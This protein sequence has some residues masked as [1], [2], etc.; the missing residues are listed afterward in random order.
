MFKKREIPEVHINWEEMNTFEEEKVEQALRDEKYKNIISFILNNSKL[1]YDK[2]RL[3]IDY[4]EVVLEYIK[5]IEPEAYRTQYNALKQK[6]ENNYGLLFCSPLLLHG[7]TQ[8]NKYHNRK[9]T[10]DGIKFD[11]KAEAKRYVELKLLQKAGKITNL[12]LQQ[13]YELQPKYKNNKGE[14]IRAITY[15]ADFKY[16]ENGKKVVED[17]KGMETKDFKLKK[18]LLEYKYPEIDFRLIK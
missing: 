14:T 6:E 1:N 8:M 9:T 17:V 18:K 5:A 7:G 12:E 16:I 2:S 3:I 15:K 4:G 11:S 10:I 13:K